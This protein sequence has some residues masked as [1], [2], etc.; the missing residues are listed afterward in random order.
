MGIFLRI[1]LPLLLGLYLP[2]FGRL[3]PGLNTLFIIDLVHVS[4]LLLGLAVCFTLATNARFKIPDRPLMRFLEFNV[5]YSGALLTK[6]LAGGAFQE[7]MNLSVGPNMATLVAILITQQREFGESPSLF[8]MISRF[9]ITALVVQTVLSAIESARGELFSEYIVNVYGPLEGRDVL[10]L[11]GASQV[12]LFGFVIPFTGLI[13]AHNAFGIM[14][15]FWTCLFLMN[16]ELRKPIST[17][18]I[19]FVVLFGLIG[20]GTRSALFLSVASILF[21]FLHKRLEKRRFLWALILVAVGLFGLI[22]RNLLWNAL[23]DFYY[24]S[25][26]LLYRVLLWQ[27]ILERYLSVENIWQFLFGLPVQNIKLATVGVVGDIVSVESEYIRIY[28]STGIVGVLLFFRAFGQ[29]LFSR[30]RKQYE[31]SE[32]SLLLL[33]LNV[34]LISIVMTGVIFFAV[35]VVITVALVQASHYRQLRALYGRIP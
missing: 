17:L 8:I 24:Q 32:M 1:G 9:L 11:F 19:I 15:L 13:G 16:H 18:L 31:G 3:V 34:F 20:N 4:S 10:T 21:F 28:L 22:Y 23:L 7:A 25:D 33:S 12:S 2:L 5:F 27:G 26:T 29:F 14:L 6:G 35:Y 30:V